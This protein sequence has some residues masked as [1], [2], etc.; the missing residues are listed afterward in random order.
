MFL[1]RKLFF[2]SLFRWPPKKTTAIFCLMATRIRF[3]ISMADDDDDDD[4][5]YPPL[6]EQDHRII[7]VPFDVT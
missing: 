7:P 6:Q 3:W 5:D 1:E 2:G 4:D